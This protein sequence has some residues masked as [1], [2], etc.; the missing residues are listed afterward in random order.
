[1]AQRVRHNDSDSEIKRNR[2]GRWL[3]LIGSILVTWASIM[4]PT[5]YIVSLMLATK[6]SL[7]VAGLLSAWATMEVFRHLLPRYF[8][9]TVGQIRAFVT[10]NPLMATFK[11][12]GSPNV[13]YGP[14]TNVCYPWEKR[15][16]KGNVS[17]DI[18]TIPFTEQ[19]PGKNTQLLTTGSYQTKPEITRADKFIG[20]DAATLQGGAIDLIKAKVSADLATK[21]ADEAKGELDTI[22]DKL[23]AYF[24]LNNEHPN[25]DVSKFED[26]YGIHTVKVTL[27]GIDMPPSVQATRDAIDKANQVRK[28]LAAM[29]SMSEE[30][31][32]A[33]VKNG[34]IKTE[35]YNDMVDRFAAMSGNATLEVKANK[36]SGL[37]SVAA[38]LGAALSGL[39]IKEKTNGGSA[40]SRRKPR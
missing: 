12:K 21:T 13:I 39:K 26:D 28:G 15:S 7:M 6:P 23:Y 29:F 35:Q 14:G 18:I 25:D 17:L 40:Q 2:K 32:M 8:L 9:I 1:M 19:V 22:N 11:I 5:T 27:S 20:V 16:A 30:D 4:A 38:A 3:V 31:L 34:V 33:A 24:G 10:L 36:Y 37:D